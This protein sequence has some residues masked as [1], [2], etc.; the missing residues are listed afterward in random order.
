MVQR[1]T[2]EEELLH[3]KE[4][5]GHTSV[6]TSD[7][8]AEITAMQGSGRPLPA[9]ERAFFEPRFGHD[10]S[11]VRVYTDAKA[12]R[13]A[14]AVNARAFT[15]G[16]DIVFGAGRQP[17]F[18]ESRRLLAH[19]LTHVLQQ[20]GSVPG[21][22]ISRTPGGETGGAGGYQEW[23]LTKLAAIANKPG[24][25]SR[26]QKSGCPSNYCQ[27]FADRAEAADDLAE[28]RNCLL[29]GILVKL[30]EGSKEGLLGGPGSKAIPYWSLYLSGG[31][32]PQ[33][34]SSDRGQD[35]TR[36]RTTAETTAFI[37]DELR[38]DMEANHADGLPLSGYT[39]M[40]RVAAA[41]AAINT[42]GDKHEMDFDTPKEVAGNL[43]GG[44]GRDQLANPIGATPSPW[45][46][47]RAADV[48]AGLTPNAD[49]SV[50][51]TPHIE[52]V[53]QDT[54]DLCPGNCG[55]PEERVAT[56]PLSR[57]E[58][59]DLTGDVPIIVRFGAPPEELNPF[60]VGLGSKPT[61]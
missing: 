19:E 55:L 49:G 34:L 57:F 42:P 14:Q 3:P 4:G 21:S 1:Q 16:R 33:D 17:S 60:N 56:I 46:D 25:P 30:S 44:V 18:S 22:R 53:V 15:V 58:A 13:S 52:F 39:R 20:Q 11:R 26:Y 59:T 32:G 35:F 37:V 24:P 48:R 31:A 38:K 5:T 54:I 51:V 8:D 61:P 41:Q 29:G 10:F 45:D 6:V 2:E 27:P 7:V 43:A 47:L 23:C 28:V 12:A 50:T 36:S 40:P 9:S